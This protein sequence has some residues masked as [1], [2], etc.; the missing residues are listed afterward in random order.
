MGRYAPVNAFES[1]RFSGIRTFA[2][3]PHVRD[4]AGVDVAVCGIPFDT[5]TSYRTGARF[6]PA[7]VREMS[8]MLRLYNPSLDVNV[9]DHLSVVDYGDLPT[10]P[11]YIEDTYAR[12]EAGLAPILA[13]GV[14]PIAIGGDHSIT[15]AELRA[16]ARRYGPVGFI[17][18]DS[19]ADTWDEYFGRKYNH[20]T[21]FRRAVEEGLIDTARA[22]QVGMRGSLYG[23]EDLA[24]S[25]ALG[26]ELWT[27][28]DVRR[29]GLAAVLAAIRQRVGSGPVFLTF[30][31][32]F[33]DPSFAPGTGTPEVGGFTSREAQELVRGLVGID[34]VGM[35]LVE[36]L[37]A[38]DPNGI[39]ALIAANVIFEFLSVLALN[40]RER[41]R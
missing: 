10:V 30:D 41:G 17:Q 29:E 19:H 34:V 38:H 35:D 40:R 16:V 15:L 12:V 23:P 18:F 2:R 4:L 3:L 14:I 6:G 8:A 21:P 11:G 36:V 33:V 26:F 7:A 20:G 24:Q 28:D 22:I 13:A 39:T 32:D 31:I 5:G 27:T 25:R 1:P 9:Y 37:P